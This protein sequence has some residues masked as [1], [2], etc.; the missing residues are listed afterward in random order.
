[1]KVHT[2]EEELQSLDAATIRGAAEGTAAALAVSVPA[3]YAAHRLWPAYRRLPIQLKVMGIM[4]ITAPAL[5]IQAER[6]TTQFD[7]EYHWCDPCTRR[8][9]FPG[10][11]C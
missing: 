11:I 2:T 1:M 6:R 8:I 4:I 5:A 3:S 7:E 10:D 9:G